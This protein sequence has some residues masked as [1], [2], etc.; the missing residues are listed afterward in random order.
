MVDATKSRTEADIFL[1]V[2]L[3]D[4]TRLTGTFKTSNFLIDVLK[5]LIPEKCTPESNSVIIYMR[6]E[7]YGDAL[8]STTLRS[9]G[10]TGGRAIFR[11]IHK[12]PEELKMLV[13]FFNFR[14]N[15]FNFFKFT[16][17]RMYHL[18]L[19]LSRLNNQNVKNLLKIQ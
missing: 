14:I 1:A 9:L 13:F 7:V 10:L 18:Y 16:D 15:F 5:A 8:E 11:L 6:K 4:G 12:K 2:Q 19:L 3:E 17:R